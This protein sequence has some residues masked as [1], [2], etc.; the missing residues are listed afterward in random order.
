MPFT[1]PLQIELQDVRAISSSKQH[2]LGQL[3]Y[4]GDGRVFA[5]GQAGATALAPGKLAQIPAVVANHQALVNTAAV[6]VGGTQLILTLGG[7]AAT[8]DQYADGFAIIRDTS[9]TGAGQALPI[10]GNSAQTSTTGN[11]TVNLGEGVG[12]ALT[13]ASVVNLE[14]SPYGGMLISDHTVTTER[15][16]GVPQVSVTAAYYAWFQVRGVSSVLGNGSIT[17]GSGIIPSATTDGAVDIEGTG[18]ITQRLGT[19]LQTGTTAKY[20]TVFLT[21]S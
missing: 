6:A 8:A 20:N 2:K 3:A 17:K 18:T 21:I 4:T 10:V 15:V 16:M 7:T 1:S 13:T 12:V 9:T 11:V 14:L 19:A 5:Y